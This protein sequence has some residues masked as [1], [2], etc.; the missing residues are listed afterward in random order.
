MVVVTWVTRHAIPCKQVAQRHFARFLAVSQHVRGSTGERKRAHL[1]PGVLLSIVDGQANDACKVEYRHCEQQKAV[2]M[3]VL[4]APV[5]VVLMTLGSAIT[6]NCQARD[7]SRG[8]TDRVELDGTP[9]E[10]GA[11]VAIS[12]QCPMAGLGMSRNDG[13][14]VHHLLCHHAHTLRSWTTPSATSRA[15]NCQASQLISN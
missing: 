9:P 5:S 8:P 12:V 7:P 13:G 11:D 6:G 3:E 1:V 10:L 14:V 4:R 15:R 2:Y